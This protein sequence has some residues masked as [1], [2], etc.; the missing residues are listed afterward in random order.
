MKDEIED[1]KS[2]HFH[3]RAALRTLADAAEEFAGSDPDMIG[4]KATVQAFDEALDAARAV[5][6]ATNRDKRPNEYPH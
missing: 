5:L 1:L 4:H 2:D 3:L 6:E